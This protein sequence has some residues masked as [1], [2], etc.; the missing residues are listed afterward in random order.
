[1]KKRE[2][3]TREEKIILMPDVCTLL[4]IINETMI[5]GINLDVVQRV[6]DSTDEFLK[7]C[8]TLIVCGL[9]PKVCKFVLSNMAENEGDDFKRIKMRIQKDAI[10]TLQHEDAF[11]L[12]S[13]I[14][15]SYF[16]LDFKN[17][18][19]KYIRKYSL[20]IYNLLFVNDDFIYSL[21]TTIRTLN[22]NLQFITLDR[23]TKQ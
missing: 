18:F 9:E 14:I 12:S 15:F 3:L 4:G 23:S 19:I 8:Y 16:G 11:N 20:S 21:E 2:I 7:Y 17:D 10:L 22:A 6:N 13:I 5:H 1:M